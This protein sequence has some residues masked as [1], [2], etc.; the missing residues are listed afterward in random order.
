MCPTELVIL[1]RIA[2]YS[3]IIR[4]SDVEIWIIPSEL[5]SIPLSPA[6]SHEESDLAFQSWIRHGPRMVPLF[7]LRHL[8]SS[9]VIV[10]DGMVPDTIFDRLTF[11]NK[12]H[13]LGI[14]DIGNFSIGEGDSNEIREKPFNL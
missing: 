11:G 8:P 1:E 5:L 3:I 7:L 6:S 12:L 4:H 14:K 2:V 13:F 9:L 10:G